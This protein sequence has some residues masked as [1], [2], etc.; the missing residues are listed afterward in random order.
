MKIK[1]QSIADKG[2]YEKERLVMKVIADC[3][4]GDFLLL[5]AGY[6]EGSVTT[7][8]HNTFWFPDEYVE[9]GDL[10]VVYS[11]S[12]K[13]NTKQL[14]S[15]KTAHFFYWGKDAALWN[16]KSK[17]PVLMHCPEWESADP[18]EL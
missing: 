7:G 10:V 11:K 12:G 5:R 18:E 9:A 17:A 6:R 13:Q 4:V 8:V 15:G 16:T 14:N 1:I 3:D 2:I